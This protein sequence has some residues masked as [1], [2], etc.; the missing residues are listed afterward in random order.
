MHGWPRSSVS[1]TH[2]SRRPRSNTAKRSRHLRRVAS[3][4][5]RQVRRDF[6]LDEAAAAR[7]LLGLGGGSMPAVSL[8]GPLVLDL[9]AAE[10][11]QSGGGGR[12]MQLRGRGGRGGAKGGG[13]AGGVQ[14]GDR[15]AEGAAGGGKGIKAF[16]VEAAG[17]G[18]GAEREEQ[19]QQLPAQHMLTKGAV[20]GGGGIN[21]LSNAISIKAASGSK[22]RDCCIPVLKHCFIFTACYH[23]PHHP[24]PTSQHAP[25]NCSS[26]PAPL[27]DSSTMSSTPPA[28]SAPRSHPSSARR[29]APP[30]AATRAQTS[31]STA[32]RTLSARRGRC[33]SGRLRKRRRRASCLGAAAT[34][35]A[36]GRGGP[37]SCEGA[38]LGVFCWLLGECGRTVIVSRRPDF[39]CA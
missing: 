22:V 19:Q 10:A 7:L 35:V 17:S 37:R 9:G 18:D 30:T 34:A 23:R 21:P 29:P 16:R 8:F 13:G 33:C 11:A 3:S 25:L 32:A 14:L 24:T 4:L 28:P 39:I 1:F 12:Q 20:A 5:K 2:S 26:P 27:P 6:N 36:A 38:W 31:G 15:A